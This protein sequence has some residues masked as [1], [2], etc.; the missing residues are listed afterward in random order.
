[1]KESNMDIFENSKLSRFKE[2]PMWF[3][4][5]ILRVCMR[6]HDGKLEHVEYLESNDDE[7]KTKPIVTTLK[8]LTAIVPDAIEPFDDRIKVEAEHI[9]D[10]TCIILTL[11]K[12]GEYVDALSGFKI[13]DSGIKG[14]S[15]E[16]IYGYTIEHEI[17]LVLDCSDRGFPPFGY[18]S[19]EILKIWQESTAPYGEE[20]RAHFEKVQRRTENNFGK[21]IM[22]N[23][24]VEKSLNLLDK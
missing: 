16:E 1:M 6:N 17:Y 22:G 3:K 9:D 23:V 24:E 21:S 19:D 20:I 4:K 13:S 2:D 14:Y 10:D 11:N 5:A 8:Y 12:D 18:V 15:P 7:F